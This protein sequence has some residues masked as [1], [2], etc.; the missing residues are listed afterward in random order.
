MSPA[1]PPRPLCQSERPSRPGSPSTASVPSATQLAKWTFLLGVGTV[2]LRNCYGSKVDADSNGR[3][4]MNRRSAVGPTG[5]N[6][7]AY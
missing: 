3:A 1:A 6:R 2:A 4:N 7:N 5:N